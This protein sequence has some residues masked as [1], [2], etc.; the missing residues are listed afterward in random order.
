MSQTSTIFRPSRVQ[1]LVLYW[2]QYKAQLMF[3]SPTEATTCVVD[4]V[5]IHDMVKIVKKI[6][7]VKLSKIVGSRQNFSNFFKSS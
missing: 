3:Q 1:N 2:P 5:D 4:I 6:Q 7:I